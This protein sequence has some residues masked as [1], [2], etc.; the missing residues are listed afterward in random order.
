MNVARTFS[1][2][3]ALLSRATCH[4][5]SPH[6]P[7]PVGELPQENR[8]WSKKQ[9]SN[10]LDS[11]FCG[12]TDDALEGEWRKFVPSSNVELVLELHPGEEQSRMSVQP[13]GRDLLLAERLK[14]DTHGKRETTRDDGLSARNIGSSGASN[15]T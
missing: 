15:E 12:A 11:L 5:V 13:I 7:Y 8:A 1:S 2:T 14:C 6:I 10:A 3:A 4:S 9:S